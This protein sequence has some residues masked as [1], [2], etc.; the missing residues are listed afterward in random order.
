[1][2]VQQRNAHEAYVVNKIKKK[3]ERIKLRQQRLG[4]VVESTDH[5]IGWYCCF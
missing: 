3:L 4:K 5:Y 2:R 1:M